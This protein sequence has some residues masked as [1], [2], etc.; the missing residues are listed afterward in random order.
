[1]FKKF[2]Y[3]G[4]VL[5]LSSLHYGFKSGVLQAT[6]E[7]FF[8]FRRASIFTCEAK[9]KYLALT[10]NFALYVINKSSNVSS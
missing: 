8:S 9:M 3:C 4:Q 5:R 6:T 1:M 10:K 7:I 2:A